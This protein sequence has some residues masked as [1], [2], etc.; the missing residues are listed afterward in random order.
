MGDLAAG[1]ILPFE[2]GIDHDERKDPD[3][4]EDI[5]DDNPGSSHSIFISYLNR[6]EEFLQL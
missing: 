3:H 2:G 1:L 6:G 5:G 4:D